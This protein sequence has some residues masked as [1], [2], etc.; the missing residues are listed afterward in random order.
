MK[1]R[2]NRSEIKKKT[3]KDHD[4]NDAPGTGT[5]NKGKLLVDATSAPEDISQQRA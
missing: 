4:K 2:Q 1:K 3:K 5:K